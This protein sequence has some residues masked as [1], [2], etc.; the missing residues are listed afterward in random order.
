M[1]HITEK[2][3]GELRDKLEA[4]K[5]KLKVTDKALARLADLGYDAHYG[6]RPLVRVIQDRVKKPLSK[7]ILFGA[8]SKGGTVLI[9]EKDEDITLVYNP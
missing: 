9:E 2:F 4:K 7:E 8:L 6:A 5:I 3:L 1:I